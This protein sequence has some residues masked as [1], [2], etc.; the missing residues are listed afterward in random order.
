MVELLKS[1][2]LLIKK[3][4][5]ISEPQWLLMVA[6]VITYAFG[7][8]YFNISDRLNAVETSIKANQTLVL[9]KGIKEGDLNQLLSDNNI[10]SEDKIYNQYIV[11]HIV[12]KF[13][14]K[15]ENTIPNL[16]ELNKKYFSL[17][18]ISVLKK[19]GEYGAKR[20]KHSS[21]LL[22]N[23]DEILKDTVMLRS[24]SSQM[25][26]DLVNGVENQ[27]FTGSVSVENDSIGWLNKN[28][29]KARG[30]IN[31]YSYNKIPLKGVVV[32]LKEE[33]PS[34][35]IQDSLNVLLRNLTS[36]EYSKINPDSLFKRQV[37]YVKTDDEGRF[38]FTHLDSNKNYSIIPIQ[39]G[40][41]FGVLKGKPHPIT[42]TEF[43]FTR[44][45]HQ[46]PLFE[47]SQFK[48]IKKDKLLVVRAPLA[49]KESLF[50]AWILLMGS[51]ILTLIM[52]YLFNTPMEKGHFSSLI[53]ILGIGNIILFSIQNPLVDMVYAESAAWTVFVGI[54]IIFIFSILFKKYRSWLL[55]FF[56]ETITKKQIAYKLEVLKEKRKTGGLLIGI[57]YLWSWCF[58]A[59]YKIVSFQYFWVIVALSLLLALVFFGSG[60]E[61]SGVN[62]KLGPFQISE[63]IK[64][65]L[66][67]FFA[68]FFTKWMFH[69]KQLMS[70]K[71]LVN[72]LLMLFLMLAVMGLYAKAGDLG[73][74]LVVCITFILFYS[75]SIGQLKLT[76]ILSGLY[77]LGLWVVS[78]LF[79][80]FNA[81]GS[82]SLVYIICCILLTTLYN[83]YQKHTNKKKNAQ[84]GIFLTVV[85]SIFVFG[86]WFKDSAGFLQRLADR[87]SVFRNIWD[88]NLYGGN[89]IAEGVWSL[90]SGRFFGQGL[91]F[92]SSNAMPAFHTDMIFQSIGEELGFVILFF[93]LTAFY[94]L[95]RKVINIGFNSKHT[96]F[97]YLIVGI[98]LANFVQLFIILFGSLG[99]TP[100][101]GVSVPL[102]SKGNSGLILT[103]LAF[104]LPYL[105]QHLIFND[106]DVEDIQ[107]A[108]TFKLQ[109]KPVVK[110]IFI[111]SFSILILVLFYRAAFIEETIIKPSKTK[112][113]RGD[114]VLTYN[115]RIQ[116]VE[117]KLTPAEIY[118]RHGV[119][120]ATSD[121]KVLK[122]HKRNL[123]TIGASLKDYEKQLAGHRSR[124]YPFGD[125][126]L[127]MLGDWNEKSTNNE[128]MGYVADYRLSEQLRGFKDSAVKTKMVES[129]FQ[130]ATYLPNE[131]RKQYLAYRDYSNYK[132]FVSAGVNSTIIKDF[133]LNK[134]F[135]DVQLSV[136]I[137]LQ[138]GITKALDEYYTH[139]SHK[140]NTSFIAMNASTG[141]ILAS[142]QYPL[143]KKED[144]ILAH[145]KHPKVIKAEF[146]DNNKLLSD[147][148]F[149]LFKNNLN[150]GSI[151]KPLQAMAYLKKY[152][153]KD[154]PVYNFHIKERIYINNKTGYGEPINKVTM[155][156]AI[157]KSSNLYFISL[158]NQFDYDNEVYDLF[159]HVGVRIGDWRTN[160]G[161]FDLHS[162]YNGDIIA[163]KIAQN[164]WKNYHDNNKGINY[165][166]PEGY[167]F[168]NGKKPVN[169]FKG[170]NYS[171]FAW[172]E[173]GIE[174]SP[175]QMAQ[176]Y[177][178]FAND[179]E[180]VKPSFLKIK[181]SEVEKVDYLDG[182]LN[183]K[184]KLDYIENSLLKQSL[185]L[186]N[187]T[188][189]KLRGKTGS[190][191]QGNGWYVSYCNSE[192]YN[193]NIV[194]VTLV[195]N[196]GRNRV[197]STQAKMVF[198][199]LLKEMYFLKLEKWHSPI[200]QN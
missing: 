20:Y 162:N 111:S 194:F 193:S 182:V 136:D 44:K 150:P 158:I 2:T 57:R 195:E 18:A 164:Y 139:R 76:L 87:N 107:E 137:R 90:N 141:E 15:L 186:S 103:V 52:Y 192:A 134:A 65:I 67:V 146:A 11:K 47:R 22:G 85:I 104:L 45:V 37:Y 78:Q 93:L 29:G 73:P 173:G 102:L 6:L 151:V 196:N 165:N 178:V 30:T 132:D 82:F 100:L 59:I 39:H 72:N 161:G 160:R 74:A 60:P 143:V 95:F 138:L 114:W 3:V 36:Q 109:V 199:E 26:V 130:E 190:T 174:V 75:I 112:T 86:E 84:G 7:C 142:V 187:V 168:K 79:D 42:Q 77:L 155:N 16:G 175:F 198:K 43:S 120:L 38:A 97:S 116:Q 27:Q 69:N 159:R 28:I 14:E 46:L 80:Q 13:D 56:S 176:L 124:Y 108:T 185:K 66:L 197:N 48:K 167:Y 179:G 25:V 200:K 41:E 181:E 32:R 62:V 49:Y 99:I 94:I 51:I 12:N 140:H 54:F 121:K 5:G 101:T 21:L 19:G 35:V 8:Y 55:S 129:D 118:S 122:Q 166:K 154:L 4:K 153:L 115:P 119:L 106:S 152:E 89:Q 157:E 113:K 110:N 31:G 63:P 91:G 70:W 23:Y 88:N 135:N 184:E 117:N 98:G 163:D 126:M 177:S 189:V 147:K 170:A 171:F 68:K 183:R 128:R 123:L 131:K 64:Y 40:Y 24:L 105:F 17:N 9:T 180:I 58:N 10:L 96:F 145:T 172:G 92:G 50:T 125:R 148:D 127:F 144:V 61:G 33:I 1:L 191:Q 133:E 34:N 149:N 81:L 53:F 188:K 169:R 156:K 71:T 83:Y